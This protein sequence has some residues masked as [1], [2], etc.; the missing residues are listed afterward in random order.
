MSSSSRSRASHSINQSPT[1]P[2]EATGQRGA[3]G[4]ESVI[5]R[6]SDEGGVR[7]TS[8]DEGQGKRGS[9]GKHLGAV[10]AV[11]K[12]FVVELVTTEGNSG[13]TARIQPIDDPAATLAKAG[14]R[15]SE[16][17]L[18]FVSD[19][20]VEIAREEEGHEAGEDDP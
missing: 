4:A 17:I 8:S 6:E 20:L 14:F 10:P 3:L 2:H 1:R 16:A 11:R 7:A 13:I 9:R 5:L 12:S 19:L 18:D 15:P